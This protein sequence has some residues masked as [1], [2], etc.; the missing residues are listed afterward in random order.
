MKKR[1]GKERTASP[2]RRDHE[3]AD[4]AGVRRR[5]RGP[6]L[7]GHAPATNR[8]RAWAHATADVMAVFVENSTV[9]HLDMAFVNKYVKHWVVKPRLAQACAALHRRREEGGRA[10]R[11]DALAP[12]PGR[13]NITNP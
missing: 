10:A 4:P 2:P 12:Q 8:R 9:V 11:D 7:V 3:A 13:D 1:E 6:P 5:Q